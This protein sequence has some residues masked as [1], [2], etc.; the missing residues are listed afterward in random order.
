M[1][2]GI[3]LRLGQ[4]YAILA[5]LARAAPGLDPIVLKGGMEPF[6]SFK[7][8]VIILLGVDYS[9]GHLIIE[10]I[11]LSADYSLLEIIFKLRC[12]CRLRVD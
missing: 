5:K 9:S 1:N 7:M 3:D 4:A 11:M 12:F 6:S 2:I 10:R 8:I